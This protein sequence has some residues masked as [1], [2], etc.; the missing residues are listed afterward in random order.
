MKYANIASDQA[1]LISELIKA[2]LAADDEARRCGDKSEV[3]LAFALLREK[4]SILANEKAPAGD[5]SANNKT[6]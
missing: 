6:D 4:G 5:E 2:R 1:K 3:G